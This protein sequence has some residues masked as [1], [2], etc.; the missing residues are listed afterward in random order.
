MT[1]SDILDRN[2]PQ[3][4][5][6]SLRDLVWRR[7]GIDGE[8]RSIEAERDQLFV[9]TQADDSKVALRVLQDRNA[10]EFQVRALQYLERYAPVIPVPRVTVD[11]DGQALNQHTPADGGSCVLQVLS[12]LPGVPMSEVEADCDHQTRFKLGALVAKVDTAWQGF[13]H[14]AAQQ[15][16]VWSLNECAQLTEHAQHIP[17]ITDRK[18]IID[19]FDRMSTEVLPNVA[20]LRHQV[21]HQDAHRNN[22]LVD[23]DNPQI[24]TGLIDYGDM[25]FGSIAAEVAVACDGLSHG[26][27]DPL[28][29]MCDV[30][31]GFDSVLPL[32]EQEIDIIF[33]LVCARN[34]MVATIVHARAAL[35]TAEQK[36]IESAISYFER[37][38]ELNNV[39]RYAVTAAL[40]RACRFPAWCPRS[41]AEALSADQERELRDGRR[42]FLSPNTKHF[43][44]EPQHFESS[45]GAFLFGTDGRR[46]LD[47][48]NNV[49]QVG[50]SNPHV[51]KAIARQAAALN[52]NTRYLYSS[53]VEY[54]ERLTDRLAP[55]LNA[56][57]FV[58]SGS[59][60]NDVAW[61]MARFA[62]GRSGGLLM[63]DGY[64]G[65]TEPIL[66]F[67]PG[68]PDTPLPTHLQGL[69][70]PDPYRGPYREGDPDLVE[71][72]AADA[73]RAISDLD[74]A[75]HTL[76]A[77]FID[78][79]FCSSGV[80]DVPYGY[81]QGVEKRVKSAGGMMICDEVQ[82]GFGR[83]GEWWGH[84]V[85]GVR[86][87]IVTM[88]KPAGNGHPL[89]VIVT[90]KE[91]MNDFMGSARLFSTFGGNPVACAAG[92]AV[93]DVIER[94]SLIA[95]G[96]EVG[97]YL[98]Q[99]LRELAVSQKLIGNV[100][101]RGMLAGLEFVSDQET[102]TPA[103]EE[104]KQLLELMRR[105]QVLVGKEGRDHNI[106]KLRPPLVF[107]RSHVDLFVNALDESLSALD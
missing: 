59:E 53:V 55:H 92:N 41:P 24:I 43:Y 83:M 15:Q 89:G 99:Q 93:L 44:D 80:P 87:D 86:A 9:I 39:G 101:G 78:S 79:A 26:A 73:D 40:R 20:T 28:T 84:E 10:A 97:D 34:A 107:D 69:L 63:E 57:M 61:Q 4:S 72:Y 54:A 60:A 27:E 64:H 5:E 58:N 7:Y 105:R 46:Y 36:H 76:A 71:K 49:P 6:A 90:S 85:H 102:R 1:D 56:C 35:F 31:S 22:V 103:T 81:L 37:L 16:H 62:T 98:R 96:I 51:V 17:D 47:C 8:F 29:A 94:E 3:A 11:R 21:I 68:H 14:P 12:F 82:S 13:F 91:L 106:L 88:G 67:S 25:L 19:V 70:V 30:V 23:P 100:R 65:I 45:S 18:F 38:R 74:A 66:E 42:E 75:G 2:V 50:H 52:T 48:Y 104:T 33:D 95:N 77:L 32:T